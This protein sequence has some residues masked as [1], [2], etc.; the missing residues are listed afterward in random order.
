MEVWVIRAMLFFRKLST[1]SVVKCSYFYHSN[2][3]QNKAFFFQMPS[4]LNQPQPFPFTYFFFSTNHNPPIISI[5]FFNSRAHLKKYLHFRT[6]E[7]HQH[8]L[9]NFFSKLFVRFIIFNLIHQYE[10][11]FSIHESLDPWPTPKPQLQNNPGYRQIE[12]QAMR[13]DYTT[14]LNQ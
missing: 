14:H 8:Y 7:I 12:R 9:H 5:Y 6:E 11:I 3:S 2:L 13:Q 4:P 10:T 1:T